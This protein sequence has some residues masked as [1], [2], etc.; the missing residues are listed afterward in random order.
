MLTTRAAVLRDDSQPPYTD[1]RPVGV[2]SKRALAIS[3][4]HALHSGGILRQVVTPNSEPVHIRSL[5]VT[6]L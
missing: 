6:A 3:R 4:R 1:S 2:E 5:G